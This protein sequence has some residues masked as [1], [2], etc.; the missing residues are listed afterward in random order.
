MPNSTTRAREI[1]RQE[2]VG[3]VRELREAAAHALAVGLMAGDALDVE[4]GA[5]VG[6]LGVRGRAG[7]RGQRDGNH[8]RSHG[9]FVSPDRGG[10]LPRAAVPRLPPAT[11]LAA[12]G[13]QAAEQNFVSRREFSPARPPPALSPRDPG[14]RRRDWRNA[15]RSHYVP[16][17]NERHSQQ[18]GRRHPRDRHPRRP[19][20]QSQEHRRRHSARPIGGVHRPV[21]FRQILARLRHHL[22]RGPAPLRREPVGLCPPVPRDDAEA[23][24]RPDRRP[25]ARHLDRAED[26]LEEPALDRRHRHR[27]LRLH[28]PAVGAHRRALLAGHRP[29][30]RKPDR[31]ADGRPRAGAAGRHA[32][33]RAGAGR[34]RPQGRIQEGARR[35]P[36]QG[37]SAR[38]DR[39]RLPRDRR[40][41]AAR[42]EVHPRHRRGGRPPGGERRHRHAAGGLR[43]SSA[44]SSPTV[45]PS[46]S[47]PTPRRPAPPPIAA[48]TPMPSASSSPRNSPARSPASPF[49]RSSRGCSRS[50]TRSAPARN[51]AASASSST[52]TPSW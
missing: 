28:A 18:K 12:L 39:R 49:R 35:V 20:A 42:Q 32:H 25:V 19:R 22:C 8:S 11:F 27:D 5:A 24:R 3:I 36:A 30:D 33:L 46:S 2:Q 15:A 47:S 4:D 51:A 21:R 52:S 9:E 37:L 1:A 14:L 10:I 45:S 26:H 6:R 13:G 17:L 29:A 40:G 43:S 7:L 48:A 16:E 41:Q 50:T 23:G 31:V 34:A 38:E 44:S